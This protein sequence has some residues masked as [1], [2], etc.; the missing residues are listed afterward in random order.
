MTGISWATVL[1]LA[2]SAIQQKAAAPP[3][4]ARELALSISPALPKYSFHFKWSDDDGVSVVDSIDVFTGDSTQPLQTLSDDCEMAETPL[5]PDDAN[6]WF[7]AEDLNFDGYSD[8]LMRTFQGATGN[9][10]Y[11]VWLFDPKARK[12][13]FS[14]AFSD[15]LGNYRIDAKAKTIVTS[16]N[17]SAFTF[18][19]QTYAVRDGEP[20]LILD[21]RQEQVAGK[22]PYHWVRREEKDGAMVVTEEKWIDA[23][24]KPCT[25]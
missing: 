13:E 5:K 6:S 3:Q 23:D 16:S 12:F 1:L 25:P 9:E 21:E 24:E 11:C 10:G 4:P 7:M 2:A 17:G 15:V 8:I 22:C 20:A 18:S 19:T 14:K